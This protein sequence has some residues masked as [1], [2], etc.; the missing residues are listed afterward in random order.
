LV[1]APDT[2]FELHAF[3]G[4]AKFGDVGH[5]QPGQ[6]Y[7]PVRALVGAGGF[8]AKAGTP[9]LIDSLVA[10]IYT[11]PDGTDVD[12]S[13]E[14][15]VTEANCGREISALTILPSKIGAPTST[16]WQVKMPSCDAVGE[17]VLLGQVSE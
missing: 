8:L 14:A 13:L 11:V 1:A 9:S 3:E 2:G 17:V 4:S 16:P 15:E 12:I 5:V 7:D 10:Q 6:P